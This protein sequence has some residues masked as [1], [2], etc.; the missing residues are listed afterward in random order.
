VEIGKL[1]NELLEK[2]LTTSIDNKREEVLVGS[3]IGEDNAI[4]DLKDQLLVLSTDPITG[5][6]KNLGKLAVNIS[7]NDVA[8]SGGEPVGILITI[9]APEKTR[10][11]EIEEIMKDISKAAKDLNIEI[12]GG[13]TEVTDAVNRIVLSTTVVGKLARKK[14]QEKDKIRVG[15]KV[16]I[17]KFAGIEGTSIIVNENKE[18]LKD[19]LTKEEFEEALNFVSKLSVVEEG[20]LGGDLGVNYMHDITEGG[21]LGAVWEARKAIKKGIRIDK[22]KIPV[23]GV[24]KKLGGIY[25]INIYRLISSGSMLVITSESKALKLKEELGKKDIEVSIIGEVIQED[26]LVLVD[27]IKEEEISSPGSDELYKALEF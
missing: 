10:E 19:K 25:D 15:D 4:L 5:T 3:A 23:K 24:T 2:I 6:S 18:F 11:E 13:H 8:A 20:K 22:A 12:I 21:V 16:L 7:C 1:P 17:T 9:L 26:K 27:G 14:L